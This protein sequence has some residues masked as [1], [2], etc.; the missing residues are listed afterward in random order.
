[1]LHPEAL[2]NDEA[3]AVGGRHRHVD[4][5]QQGLGDHA[6]NQV[7]NLRFSRCQ[8]LRHAGGRCGRRQRRAK[9]HGGIDQLLAMLVKQR[10][11]GCT[12]LV[13][14]LGLAI[15]LAH[16]A[17][18]QIRRLGQ[19][20]Q[21]ALGI[22]QLTVDTDQRNAGRLAHTLQRSLAFGLEKHVQRDGRKQDHRNQD[23]CDHQRQVC[24]YFHWDMGRNVCTTS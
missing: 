10:G 5:N 19:H 7:R 22:G 4:D 24:A 15:E 21:R 8:H 17:A 14:I 16:V 13:G 1:M 18:G 3:L 9:W 2:R 23:R 12:R 20:A 6:A 11:P